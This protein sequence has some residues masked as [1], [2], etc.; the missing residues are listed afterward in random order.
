MDNSWAIKIEALTLESKGKDSIDEHGSLV[1][2]T[3]YEPCLLLAS[4][5]SAM[6][7]ALSTHEDDNR[8]MVLSSKQFRRMVVDAYV[9]HKHC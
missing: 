8:L 1:L 9:Y 7:S 4:P 3:P 2:D 5:E 6:L